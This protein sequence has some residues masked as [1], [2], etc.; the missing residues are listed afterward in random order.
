MHFIEP[1]NNHAHRLASILKWFAL[2][3]RSFSLTCA[4]SVGPLPSGVR[5][6]YLGEGESMQYLMKSF[7]IDD[8]NLYQ[9]KIPFWRAG[10]MIQRINASGALLCVELNRLFDP[11][12]KGKGLLTFPW[13]RQRVY[14]DSRDYRGKRRRIEETV[15]RKVRKYRYEFRLVHDAASLERFH[16]KLYLPYVSARFGTA[17]HPRRLDELKR[18]LNKGFL[19]QVLRDNVWVSG[20]VCGVR[21]DQLTAVA[22]GHVP[23]Q[24]HS[25]RLGGLSAAYYYLFHYAAQHSVRCVDLLRSRPDSADGVY[26]HKQRWGAVAER[27]SWPHTAIRLFP[28]AE[29]PTPQSLGRILVWSGGTFQELGQVMER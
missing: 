16:E 19:L 6:V 14:L 27:D 24:Q 2:L 13:L 28:P 5:L 4:E 15:G 10:K 21:G 26:C 12:M 3:P 23:E 8:F 9:E 7:A 29:M 25:L 17:C 1:A 11:L 18:V 22:F 20:V